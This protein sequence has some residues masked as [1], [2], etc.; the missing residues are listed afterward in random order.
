MKANPELKPK[1]L[2]LASGG[3]STFAAL[4]EAEKKLLLDMHIQALVV[5]RDCGALTVAR[6]ADMASHLISYTENK[7]TFGA[8]LHEKIA[9]INPDFIMLAGFLRKIGDQTVRAY[10]NRI[11]NTHPA[12]LPDFGGAGMY[13]IN[14]HRAVVAA[15]KPM[16]GV[17]FHLVTEN[18][19]QGAVLAQKQVPVNPADTAEQLEEKIKGLEKFF[20]IE[21]LNVQAANFR[22]ANG[23]SLK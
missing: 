11:F 1:L 22:R 13:G 18:Y 7:E 2:V 5:D 10:Q 20:V 9:Q 21:Q 15:K 12:L 19:D 4:V 17:S 23:M 16:S 3:G 6:E 14:V 8:R